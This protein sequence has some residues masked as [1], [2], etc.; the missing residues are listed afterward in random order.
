MFAWD[1]IARYGFP[2]VISIDNNWD[3][4]CEGGFQTDN[5]P[6]FCNAVMSSLVEVSGIPYHQIIPGRPQGQGQVEIYVKLLK[7]NL[8]HA[9][10]ENSNNIKCKS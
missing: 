5:G 6:E 3:A 2:G 9:M 4:G 7:R 10:A 1:L 8:R